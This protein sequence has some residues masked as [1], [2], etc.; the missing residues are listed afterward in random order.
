[1][2]KEI[3][4]S[5]FSGDIDAVKD[6]IQ[7]ALDG[8]SKPGEIINQGLIKAM[9]EV[10]SRMKAGEMFVPEVLIAAEAMKE[11]LAMVKPLLEGDIYTIGK[12]VIGTVAGDL[13][14]IGKNLV[15]MLLESSGFEVV[16]LGVDVSPE[17]FLAAV[18][19]HKPDIVG[20]SALLTTTM[21]SM[22]DTVKALADKQPGVKTMIG[23]AP[24]SD[25]FSEEI[26][27]GGYASDGAAAVDLAKSLIS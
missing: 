8:G 4:N 13:H 25:E 9:D 3:Y 20:L 7:K 6:G 22:R 17:N 23:G 24:V 19:E 27:A 2:L 1:M 10:G 14:D 5:V 18:D 26:G 11:G 21:T 15:A 12:V 16:D